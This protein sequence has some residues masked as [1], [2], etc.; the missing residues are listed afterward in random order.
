MSFSHQE[1]IQAND[2]YI[3]RDKVCFTPEN[4]RSAEYIYEDNIM[5]HSMSMRACV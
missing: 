2:R 1:C 3:Y 4:A 5:S